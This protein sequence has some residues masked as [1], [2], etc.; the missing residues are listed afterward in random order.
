MDPEKKAVDAEAVPQG[1]LNEGAQPPATSAHDAATTAAGTK[2]TGQR[3][4]LREVLADAMKADK[5][6]VGAKV[7][8]KITDVHTPF[9]LTPETS[10]QPIRAADPEGLRIIRH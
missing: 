9:E 10:I 5:S 2:A 6:I 3:V 7:N 8:G 4:T 1:S